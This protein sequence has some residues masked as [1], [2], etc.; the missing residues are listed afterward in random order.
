[1]WHRDAAKSLTQVRS[2][3]E[4]GE[5]EPARVPYNDWRQVALPPPRDFQPRLPV[6]VVVPYFEAQ[7]RLA[8]TLAALEG[9]T[10][11]GDLFEVIVVDDGSRSPPR[12][13]ASTRLDISVMRQERR[14]FGLARA[15]NTGAR[16]AGH[17]ILVFLDGD[18]IADPRML[19]AHARWHHAV[20][21]A[22]TLGFRSFVDVDDLDAATVR[23]TRDL[24]GLL[25]DRPSD[26]D[27]REMRLALTD[28]L[29]SRHDAPFRAMSGCNFGIRKAF[30]LAVGGCDESFTRY[31][32]EDTEFAYRVHVHGGLTVPLREALSWHQGRWAG[33]RTRK[34]AA[35]TAQRQKTANLIAHPAYRDIV[36]ARVFDVP[37]YVVTVPVGEETAR[38]VTATV[39]AILADPETDLVVRVVFRRGA[40]TREVA[41]L[42][43]R[44]DGDP[45][46]RIGSR[47]SALD[48]F[49]ATP[50]HLTV[51]AAARLPA[52][53][54]RRLA[55]G[56]GTAVAASAVL[57]DGSPVAITRA[58]ALNRAR[59]A[60]GTAADYGA[61][62]R[63]RLGNLRL[64]AAAVVRQSRSPAW[65]RRLRAW[66]RRARHEVD[67]IHGARS[68]LIF[69]KRLRHAVALRHRPRR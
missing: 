3:V 22:L 7:R 4:Q 61:V 13:P 56:L 28:D 9:Q 29:A 44:F 54:V 23:G 1:M 24:R 37:R 11:P 14:G 30:Y 21:D 51:P 69:G 35:N 27:W 65:W 25:G 12:I 57:A 33:E 60:G 68:L 58:W 5:P 6:T 26:P 17:D 32:L 20:C 18:M 43:E 67:H 46:T 62:R 31:G 47:R 49:P 16:A 36:P 53:V 59:R 52:G 19:A 38:Q 41:R 45:R 66:V 50:F 55:E 39:D 10:Y 2:G 8:L 15:R 64:R 48:Q 63:V 34:R 42:R 40:G